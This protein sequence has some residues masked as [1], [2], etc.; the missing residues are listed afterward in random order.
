LRWQRLRKKRP[1]PPT[2]IA[3]WPCRPSGTAAG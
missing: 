3:G 2:D 1:E